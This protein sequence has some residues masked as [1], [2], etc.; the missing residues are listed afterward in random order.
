MLWHLSLP[1]RAHLLRVCHFTAHC[2]FFKD[3]LKLILIDQLLQIT[4]VV[5]F[6][7]TLS[8]STANGCF[9]LE[10]KLL[11]NSTD[12]R[13]IQERG[14]GRLFNYWGRW[15]SILFLCFNQV[16]ETCRTLS[17]KNVNCSQTVLPESVRGQL[18]ASRS[19]GGSNQIT[20]GFSFLPVFTV[21]TDYC[22]WLLWK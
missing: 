18:A 10:I 7:P 17:E 22:H 13:N 12:Y 11:G 20:G 2:T 8:Q 6:T 1:V 5:H 3:K 15:C 14:R 9:R 21:K 19:A 16:A 4:T